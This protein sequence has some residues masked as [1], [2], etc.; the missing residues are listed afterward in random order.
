MDARKVMCEEKTALLA[1]WKNAANGY[2]RT[3]S[4]LSRKLGIIPKAEY[5]RLKS[6]AEA[7]RQRSIDA[8]AKLDA[9]IQEHGCDGNGEVAA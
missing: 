3:V 6:A 7:A 5:E 4:E 2:S 8:Q 1:A 9:H